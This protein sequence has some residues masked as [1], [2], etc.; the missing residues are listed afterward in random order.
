M[1][2]GDALAYGL[3]GAIGG[4]A[5]GVMAQAAEDQ[6]REDMAS[7]QTA[8]EAR[9]AAKQQAETDRQKAV[10]EFKAQLQHDALPDRLAEIRAQEEARAR[11]QASGAG[12][13]AALMKE[14][15]DAKRDEAYSNLQELTQVPPEKRDAAWAQQKADNEKLYLKYGGNRDALYGKRQVVTENDPITGEPKT[16]EIAVDGLYSGM[17][18]QAPAPQAQKVTAPIDWSKYQ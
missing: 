17:A 5:Q 10:E 6:K 4:G 14:G 16:K 7:A 18:Q 1:G 12:T 9:D 11:I 8:Q 3:L 2:L 13:N 15:R